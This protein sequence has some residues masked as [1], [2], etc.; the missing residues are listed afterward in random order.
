[1][2][3]NLKNKTLPFE[4]SFYYG[5]IIV[6]VS[7]LGLFFSGPGQTY[8]VSVFIDSFIEDLGWSR[9]NVS[10]LYSLGTL[11]AGLTVT[12]V[13]RQ[14]DQHGHHRTVPL[15]SLIF[16]V[17]LLWMSFVVN[18]IMLFIGFYAI[19]LLGQSSMTIGPST[20]VP[21]WFQR[22]RGRAFSLMSIGEIIGAASLPPL[23]TWIINTWNWRTG[24]R[25]WTVLLWI[26]MA[27]L[28]HFL[29][30]D[31]PQEVGLE[32]D[33][34]QPLEE[35]EKAITSEKEGENLTE[36][37][38]KPLSEVRHSP[39]FWLLLYCMFVPSMVGTGL[40]FHMVSI[41]G[42]RGLSPT[43]AATVLS[44][45]AVVGFPSTLLSGYLLDRV[46]IRYIMLTTFILYAGIMVW[47][48]YV[49]NLVMAVLY[50]VF[51][52]LIMGFHRVTVNIIWPNYFGLEHLGSIRGAVQIAFVIGAAC[53]PFPMGFAYDYFGGYNEIL[54]LL[55]VF[56]LLAAVASYFAV[57]PGER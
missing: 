4:T 48:I 6:F 55:I 13:G 38:S 28:A 56:P 37:T 32:P 27:P 8:S 36:V 43:V 21:K 44:T 25:V 26:V 12:Y 22:K 45:I 24:W 29:I 41:M 30:R 2:Q 39:V 31:K 14:F 10:F 3:L 46:R 1:M 47:L 35:E 9:S 33:G 57:S 49:D 16:G 53:G 50:G 20:L 42:E 11:M 5:W 40:T 34:D 51:M 19:R 7:G 52:G 15:I 23:N 54:W 17:A 18:P